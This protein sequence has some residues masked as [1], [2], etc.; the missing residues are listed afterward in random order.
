[1]NWMICSVSTEK[2]PTKRFGSIRRIRNEV[3]H[4]EPDG[5]GEEDLGMLRKFVNSFNVSD[6]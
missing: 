4:F 1:M 3:M 5:V 2:S 6:S